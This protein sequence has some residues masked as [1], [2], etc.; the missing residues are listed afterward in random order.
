MQRVRQS[1]RRCVTWHRPSPSK[2][3][4]RPSFPRSRPLPGRLGCATDGT[5]R[6]EPPEA[7]PAAA[8]AANL[9]RA[10]ASPTVWNRTPGRAAPLLDLG[11]HEAESPSAVAA[12]SDV[13][14][15]CVS[16]TPDVDAVL[17]GPDGVEQGA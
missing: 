5:A 4:S 16:D 10:G 2:S 9:A 14:V 8:M 15:I 7:F 6:M 13:V 1:Q 17:F 11:A 3:R 12:V